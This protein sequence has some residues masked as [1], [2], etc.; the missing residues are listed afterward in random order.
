MH[1]LY[2]NHL[3]ATIA[4]LVVITVLVVLVEVTVAVGISTLLDIDEDEVTS[5]V[6]RTL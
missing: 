6:E 2:C 5:A 4:S 3:L 1:V